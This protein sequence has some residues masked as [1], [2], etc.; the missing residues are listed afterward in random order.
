MIKGGDSPALTALFLKLCVSYFHFPF[1]W[2]LMMPENVPLVPR[3]RTKAPVWE[4]ENL[5]QLE[6]EP[7]PRKTVEV[8]WPFT[9]AVIVG[10]LEKTM[11]KS[12][13]SVYP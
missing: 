8:V 6:L 2:M 11:G 7:V 13:P 5:L 1:A 4:V 10:S 12:A 9:V 3:K